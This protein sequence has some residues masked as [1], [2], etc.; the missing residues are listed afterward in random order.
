MLDLLKIPAKTVQSIVNSARLAQLDVPYVLLNVVPDVSMNSPLPSRSKPAE[1]IPKQKPGNSVDCGSSTISHANLTD[2]SKVVGPIS[3]G[4]GNPDITSDKDL[5][6]RIMQQSRKIRQDKDKHSDRKDKRE[7]KI[8]KNDSV[9]TISAIHSLERN[10]ASKVQSQRNSN[11]S[12]DDSS[13]PT[14]NSRS[15]KMSFKDIQVQ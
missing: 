3:G 5:V 11:E 13:R 15:A 12:K 4:S 6:K 8:S 14:S 2:I 9:D 1:V 10:S 7:S